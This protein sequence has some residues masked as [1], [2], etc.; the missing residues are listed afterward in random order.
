VGKVDGEIIKFQ[1]VEEAML[2]RMDVQAVVAV[3]VQEQEFIWVQ[4]HL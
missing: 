3:V 1:V 4:M 2:V